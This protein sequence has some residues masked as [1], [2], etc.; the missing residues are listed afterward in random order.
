MPEGYDQNLFQQLYKETKALRKKLAYEIDGRKFGVDNAEVQSCFDVKFLYIFNKYYG[1]PKLKGY[2]INGLKM[3]KRRTILN[4]YLDKNLLHKTDD[5]TETYDLGYLS[6]EGTE[7]FNEEQHRLNLAKEYLKTILSEDAYLI[8]EIDL[9]PPPYILERMKNLDQAKIPK[10]PTD[11]IA[12]FL[13]ITDDISF[14]IKNL[15]KEVKDGIE[16]ANYYFS[17]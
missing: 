17:H 2:I 11:L 8:F 15:R 7:L 3:F 6:E 4:S 13:G 14:Y 5:I 16:Q 12:E 1:N 9:Y 10:I